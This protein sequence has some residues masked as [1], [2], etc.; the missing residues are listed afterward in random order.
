MKIIGITGGIGAGKSEILAYIQNRYRARAI[1]AD[2]VANDIKKPQGRLY[3]PLVGLLGREVL[4]DD[5]TIDKGKMARI[6]FGNQEKLAAVNALVHPAV[7]QYILDGIETERALCRLD[8]LFI[9]A[10]LLIEEHYERIVDEM[11]YVYAPEDVRR[12][13]LKR[14]RGYSD[15]KITAIMARQSPETVFREKCQFVIDNSAGLEKAYEQINR[16]MEG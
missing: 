6:I 2:Q 7:K 4:A 14:N 10:A 16:R 3:E 12:E 8:W 1:L 9:E 5:K 15:E 13:R 11:W